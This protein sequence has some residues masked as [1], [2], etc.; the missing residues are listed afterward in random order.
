[1]SLTWGSVSGLWVPACLVLGL[2][3]AWLLYRKPVQLVK[4]IRYA[5]FA[6]RV[7]VVSFL[8]LLLVSPLVRSSSYLPQKPVVLIAQDNSESIKLFGAL[9][10]PSPEGRVLSQKVSPIGGDLEGALATLKKELGD[11]Y[12]VHEFHFD[13]DLKDNL[14]TKYDGR[15]TNISSALHQLNERFVNRNIGALVLATDGLYNLGTDPQ[16]EARNIKTNIYTIALGDTIPRRD[17]LISNVNYNK[18]AFLGNDFEVETLAEAYQSAGEQM[19]L[20]ITQ[21]GRQVNA[22]NIAITSAAFKKVIPVK[23]NADKKGIRKF[24]ISLAP[25]KNELSVKNNTETIYIDV[26]DARQK[27]LLLYDGPHPD[28]AVIKQGIENNKNFEVKTSLVSDI[29][30]L[31]L[32]DYS[33]AILYQLSAGSYG[34]LQTLLQSKTP[35]WHIAGTQTNLSAFNTAQKSVKVTSNSQE[36][37]EAFAQPVST[38]SAFI[39]TDSTQNKLSK[40]PPL[41]AAFG[42]YEALGTATVLLKQKIGNVETLYPLLAFND[43]GG[44]KSAVLAGEG[45]WRWQLAEYREFGNHHAVEELLSQTVQYLTANANRQRFRVYAS[46]NVFD[47]GE[48]VLLNAELYNDALE[49]INTPDVKINLKSQS[50]KNYSFLFTRSGQSYQLNAGTLPVGEYT[51]AATT[52]NGK[53]AFTA[54]GQ[55]TIKQLNLETRQSTANHQLLRSIAAQSG[56]QMLLPSQISK[57]ADLIRKNENIKTVV[58][59]DKRYSDLIDVKWFFVLILLL[60]SAEWFLRK[61]EG[62]I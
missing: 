54:N 61:R 18:T 10:K 29:S 35:L 44:R 1:M 33:M 12:E 32:A 38:F 53:Q 17:L 40:L 4:G 48:N 43:E 8:A 60:L 52:S 46:K 6:F 22:Q 19:R 50:G 34:K 30:S 41:V 3:Y 37:Q 56:G 13:K 58:Y 5:L 26:L 16:Y 9:P 21:D 55:I 36:V 62:E 59:E 20:S 42:N 24:T 15:Q 39:L 23:L 7:L 47:E 25:V 31:K 28:L 57:L 45:L 14:S 49:L 11:N 27:I 2:L 51:Y